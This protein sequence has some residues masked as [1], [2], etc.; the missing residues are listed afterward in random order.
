MLTYQNNTFLR[1][2]KRTFEK[3]ATENPFAL[4]VGIWIGTIMLENNLA[5]FSKAGF[6]HIPYGTEIL[7][8]DVHPRETPEHKCQEWFSQEHFL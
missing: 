2:K 7:C 1:E 8:L 6:V 5:L 4:L 3:Y